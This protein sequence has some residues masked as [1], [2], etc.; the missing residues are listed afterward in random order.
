MQHAC[1]KS[2]ITLQVLVYPLLTPLPYC[3]KNT[4]C[5][6]EQPHIRNNFPSALSITC[7]PAPEHITGPGKSTGT[8]Q[9]C[10]YYNITEVRKDLCAHG[11]Q[12][13]LTHSASRTSQKPA[14]TQQIPNLHQYSLCTDFAFPYSNL[15]LAIPQH[16]AVMLQLLG[17]ASLL[18]E[19]HQ[20]HSK[21]LLK[22]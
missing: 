9:T 20:H 17:K 22:R 2:Y 15:P 1:Y 13:Y 19:T 7:C 3:L 8:A 16:H 10:W 11:I 4:N 14:A 6:T 5:F 21:F 12:D 18:A